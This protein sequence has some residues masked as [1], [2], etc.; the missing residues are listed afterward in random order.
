MHSTEFDDQNP[1]LGEA[2]NINWRTFFLYLSQLLINFV[3]ILHYKD[4]K[5]VP[6]QKSL[7]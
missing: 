4:R 3:G 7:L 5:E 1:F 2:L 6:Y